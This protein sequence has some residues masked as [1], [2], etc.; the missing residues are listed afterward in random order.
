MSAQIPSMANIKREQEIQPPLGSTPAGTPAA[1]KETDLN[2]IGRP[3]RT[4]TERKKLITDPNRNQ[5][6]NERGS[7]DNTQGSQTG[8]D[9][10]TVPDV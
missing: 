9:V 3:H 8:N 5:A 1:P 10:D 7:S 4:R 2:E 6:G